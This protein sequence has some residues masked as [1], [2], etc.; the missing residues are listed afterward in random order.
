MPTIWVNCMFRHRLISDRCD[1]SYLR[2]LL[3]FP[4]LNFSFCFWKYF[5][6]SVS[7]L[8]FDFSGFCKAKLLSKSYPFM[9]FHDNL[10]RQIKTQALVRVSFQHKSHLHSFS[11]VW[12][13][14]KIK[15]NILFGLRW[16]ITYFNFVEVVAVTD[17]KN[18]KVWQI[19]WDQENNISYTI[20][21]AS[22]RMVGHIHII[23]SKLFSKLKKNWI[24]FF[25]WISMKYK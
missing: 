11:Q 12:E 8:C 13:R 7:Q 6:F 3:S 5:C 9:R 25:S 14:I 19:P 24:H 22:V 4:E 1:N 23:D 20:S 17:I 16:F 15:A 21:S 18:C 10:H 2:A